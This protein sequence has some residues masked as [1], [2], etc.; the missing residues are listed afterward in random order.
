MLFL[1]K[2]LLVRGWGIIASKNKHTTDLSKAFDTVVSWIMYHCT[3]SYRC[4]SACRPLQ[5]VSMLCIVYT[6]HYSECYSWSM[7]VL[8]QSF[9]WHEND[10]FLVISRLI[11]IHSQKC[12]F[13]RRFSFTYATIGKIR[14]QTVYLVEYWYHL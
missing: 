10:I 3:P 7:S 8:T 9:Q 4:M 2:L 6:K 11:R 14:V 1:V 5:Y 13:L 12:G